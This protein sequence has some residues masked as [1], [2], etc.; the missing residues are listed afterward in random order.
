[1]IRVRDLVVRFGTVVALDLPALEIEPGERL[2]IEGP[3]GCG[4]STLLRTLAGLQPPSA[5]VVEGLPPR[6]R[7]VLVHQRPY[8][9][10][11]TAEANVAYALRLCG[12]PTSDARPLLERLGANRLADR[13]ASSLSE[14][15]GR[16]V[17]MARALAVQ[18][19]VLLLD[20]SLSAL[21]VDGRQRVRDLLEELDCTV[22]MAAPDLADYPTRRIARLQGGASG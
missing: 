14:G 20:E 12:R 9:F 22:V 10:R 11:G 3:N 4:K 17:A 18:P 7:V 13:P 5:G 16:R 19:E 6:G 2:G 8:F 15:E 1:M 21:D